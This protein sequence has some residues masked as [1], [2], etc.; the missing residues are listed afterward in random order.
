MVSTKCSSHYLLS[1]QTENMTALAADGAGLSVVGPTLSAT[2]AEFFG[3][4]EE[5]GGADAHAL[6]EREQQLEVRVELPVFEGGDACRGHACGGS[7]IAGVEAVPL[8]YLLDGFAE[9]EKILMVLLGHGE[10]ILA[11]WADD[12]C[13]RQLYPKY[14]LTI[15]DRD[16]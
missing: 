7:Q 4:Q 13:L 8:A 12:K 6:R 10:E 1:P 15:S 11:N 5:G 16:A 3:S 2:A 14:V 9:D